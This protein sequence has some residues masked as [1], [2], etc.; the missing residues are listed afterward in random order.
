VHRS[1]LSELTWNRLVE[2]K[3]GKLEE[4]EEEDGLLLI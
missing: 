3:N 2:R 4:E 1:D